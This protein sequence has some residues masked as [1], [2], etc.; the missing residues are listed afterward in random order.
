MFYEVIILVELVFLGSLRF[1]RDYF[2]VFVVR[3][4]G[5]FLFF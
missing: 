4:R 5:L 3:F 1:D 2:C